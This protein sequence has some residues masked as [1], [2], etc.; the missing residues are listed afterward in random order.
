MYFF[1]RNFP[2]AMRRGSS[3]SLPRWYDNFV[4]EK[5]NMAGIASKLCSVDLHDQV[6]V[7]Y[8][9][10]IHLFFQMIVTFKLCLKPNF[11][12]GERKT[13]CWLGTV[14]CLEWQI[15]HCERR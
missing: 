9:G 7:V 4:D 11:A 5:H 13:C 15:T 3:M 2:L 12:G 1:A 8:H 14:C 10:V 6:H